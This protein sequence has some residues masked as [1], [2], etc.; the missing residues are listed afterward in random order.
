M[1]HIVLSLL[2]LLDNVTLQLSNPNCKEGTDAVHTKLASGGL[3]F[4]TP[5]PSLQEDPA[6]TRWVYARG[7]PFVYSNF[8]PTNKTSLLGAV[9]GVLPLFVLCYVLKTDRVRLI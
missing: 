2:C 9:F 1:M 8:R 6:L 4:D 5:V 3:T 7:H